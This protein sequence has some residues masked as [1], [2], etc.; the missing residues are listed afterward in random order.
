VKCQSGTAVSPLP[1]LNPTNQLLSNK[2]IVA[3]TEPKTKILV[4][5][6]G[7]TSHRLSDCS[8]VGVLFRFPPL[9]EFFFFPAL[10]EPHTYPV[11]FSSP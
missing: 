7:T 6:R 9:R 1:K 10:F 5:Q 2:V 8:D 11:A 3:D 4:S